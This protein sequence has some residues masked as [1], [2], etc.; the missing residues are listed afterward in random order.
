MKPKT[1]NE[2]LN[3][4]MKNNY[5]PQ[6]KVLLFLLLAVACFGKAQQWHELNTGVAED[7]YGVCC[8]DTNTV[9]VCGQNG[10]IL[11]T[12]DGGNSWQEKYRQ[13]GHQWYKIKFFDSNIGFSFGSDNNYKGKLLKTI[14]GGETWMDM[15]CPFNAYNYLSPSSCD[16]FLVDSDTLYVASDQLMKSTDGGNSFSQLEIEWL[17]ST[18]D[19]YF[20]GNVGYIVWGMAGD[21]QGTHIAK[22]TDYGASWEE[23]LSFDSEVEGIE[24]ALFHDKD[25][26]SI[27]GAFGYDENELSYVYNEIRTDDGFATYQ[28]LQT[29]NLPMDL[30]PIISSI[31]FSDPQHGIIVYLL[32]GIQGYYPTGIITYQTQDGGN[33][34]IELDALVCPGSVLFAGIS[35]YESVYYLTSGNGGVYK[36]GK[37]YEG[38]AEG[39]DSVFVF[40][41]PVS[42]TF[43]VSGEKNSTIIIYNFS[44]QVLLQQ[45]M[46][47]EIQKIEIGDFPSGLYYLGIKKCGK[48]ICLQ[49]LLKE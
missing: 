37:T 18:Q 4:Y 47:D 32:E 22:T 34:W 39:K 41:N 24:K 27:F 11:K 29:E 10:L 46:T 15:G 40:P 44:G 26:V 20:E 30:W 36:L 43:F 49:K 13:S 1:S 21:F 33:T 19:L 23:F 28:W 45:K 25:H 14:D 6:R 31:S 8:I 35:S 17:N 38:L 9:F 2:N 48:S 7:L 5:T 16:L 3:K 12:E 42:N